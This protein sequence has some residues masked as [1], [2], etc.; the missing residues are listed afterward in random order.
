[1]TCNQACCAFIVDE[2]K[3]DFKFLFYQLLYHRD[4]LKRLAVGAAQQNLSGATMK[5]F[6]LPFP[7]LPL[8]HAIARILSSLDDK[9]ELNR[10]M[11]ETLESIARAIFQSWFVDFD[12]VR[13]KVE[14]R[15]K[16]EMEAE[17]AELFPERFENSEIGEIPSGWKIERFEKILRHS[18]DRIGFEQAAEYSATLTGLTLRDDRFNKQLSKTRHKNKK[19]VKW[20][21]VFGLSR[22]IVNFGLMKESIGSVSPVYEIFKV[23]SDIYIPE[24]LEMQIR[25]DML[26]YIDILKPSA[27]EGQGID[28]EYL[29]SKVVLVPDMRVQKKYFQI[30]SIL[31][32]K[33]KNNEKQSNTLA[34]IRDVLLPKLMSGEFNVNK[35]NGIIQETNGD[36]IR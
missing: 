5:N 32:Q 25:Y 29:L 6:L 11:N 7:P 26:N 4:E 28:R 3:T 24:L 8:Q 21:L 23:N 1:M 22:K 20:D 35:V 12:P 15:Q 19:I 33:I 14:G 9:I 17:I 31:K 27:R 34:E 16:L 13:V 10:Q 18:S 30:Y 2:K 36:R